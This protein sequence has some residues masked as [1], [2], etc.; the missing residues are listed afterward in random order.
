MS[1]EATCYPAAQHPPMRVALVHAVDNRI[2]DTQMF[3]IHFMPVWA[4][5]LA[6]HLEDVPGLE[7]ELHDLRLDPMPASGPVA[8][9][10]LF[11]GINQDCDAILE[12]ARAVRA[13]APRALLVIGG[14]ICWSYEMAG[15]L[16]KLDAFDHVF[17]GDGEETLP[18]F[19]RG[20]QH[21]QVAPRIVKAAERFDLGKA[22]PMNDRLLR[23]TS[24]R[25]YGGVL[26]VSRG[27]PF[28]CEFCD[29]RVQP[30]NNRSHVKPVELVIQEVDR[31]WEL[32]IRQTLFAC[33]HFAGDPHWAE[34]VCDRLIE[35]KARTGRS[36][37]LYTWLTIDLAHH[38]RLLQKL[39]AAGFDMFFIGVESFN[40]S[41]LLETAKV[42]NTTLDLVQALRRIQSYGFIVVA[43]LIMGFDTDTEDIVDITL[44]GIREAGLISGDPSL[45]TALPGTPLYQR[46]RLSG[47]LRDAKLGLGGF[48][49]QTNIRYLRATRGIREDF[50][51]FVRDFNA[52]DYQLAR[53]AAFLDNIGASG[54]YAPPASATGYANLGRLLAMTAR[55]PLY[56]VL[57]ALRLV[58]LVGHP[59]R[60]VAI[61]RAAALVARR[62]TPQRPL[63]FY[64]KFWLFNWSN[65]IVK[66]SGLSDADFDIESVA[67]DFAM[68]SVL[69]AGYETPTGDE[70]TSKVEAQR[71]L[72][73]RSLK[74]LI[75]SRRAS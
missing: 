59:L 61:L 14:P 12:T 28:L 46:M 31:F 39:R 54:S 19:L 53:L 51:R 66:Y 37:S 18:A 44:A 32:G 35:W 42:Q 43:G 38:P 9:V 7:I 71:R 22:R 56:L 64:F 65:S 50:K 40:R 62:S 47:R 60:L 55:K 69:P 72:T 11:T 6:A 49:Y 24:A 3:G 1:A 29:I 68:E 10:Y 15:R 63:W 34:A 25:Y 41:S 16:G 20:L 26:E 75:T 2:A 36:M 67:A 52:P 17:I 74:A 48:K 30:D 45:L 4:Y 73:S 58:R 57:L 8:D 21:G 5:T 13:R 23:E 70:A 27:C 33:D